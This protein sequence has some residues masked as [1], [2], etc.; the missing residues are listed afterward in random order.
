MAN[1]ERKTERDRRV[2]SGV[3]L[4]LPTTAE[5]KVG[6]RRV[7]AILTD[8]PNATKPW[9]NLLL[10]PSTRIEETRRTECHVSRAVKV[11]IRS[12]GRE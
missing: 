12:V 6:L 5:F 10:R 1:Q 8:V 9:H 3:E 7:E 4:F 2:G 11:E